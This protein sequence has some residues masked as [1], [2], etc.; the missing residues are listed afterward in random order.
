MEPTQVQYFDVRIC[1][2]LFNKCGNLEKREIMRDLGRKAS[3]D[4]SS[5]NRLLD[6][7]ESRGSILAQASLGKE[8]KAHFDYRPLNPQVEGIQ[9]RSYRTSGFL[10]R[11]P[12]AFL[13]RG[14]E[15]PRE[16][17]GA[18][19]RLAGPSGQDQVIAYRSCALA[20]HTG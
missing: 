7:N 11:M 3:L 19:A 13:A 2:A 14:V 4:V 20:N 12:L 1:R 10:D 16:K 8:T 5:F 9:T 6:S 17:A 15:L 18:T